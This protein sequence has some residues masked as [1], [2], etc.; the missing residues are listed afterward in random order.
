MFVLD[1]I[2]QFSQHGGWARDGSAETLLRARHR[3]LGTGTGTMLVLRGII[4]GCMDDGVVPLAM[5][6]LAFSFTA[7]VARRKLAYS[8]T[9]SGR[10]R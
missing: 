9:N 7:A 5:I 3:A 6:S 8:L 1:L 10:G 4:R 2:E